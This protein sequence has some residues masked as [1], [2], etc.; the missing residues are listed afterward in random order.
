MRY[1]HLISPVFA[2]G[3]AALS[4]VPAAAGE[5]ART[6]S[7]T[8]TA[9][10]F[11]APDE[12]SFSTGVVS[13]GKTAATA[14]NANSKA[15]AAMI[16]SLKKQGVPEKAIQTANLSLSPQYQPCKPEV[17]C[18]QK[19][20]GYEVSNTLSVTVGVDKAGTVLDAL[21][22][23]GANQIGGI[24]FSIHDTKALL[25]EARA[26]AV[27][28]AIEKAETLA[29]AAGVALGPIQSIHDGGASIP[30]PMFKAMAVMAERAVPLAAGEEEVSANVSIT[31]EIK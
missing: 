2:L 22:A 5:A 31:W 21:V 9:S 27:K 29:K 14:L 16:A 13:Q 24:S 6:L 12:A 3:L 10:V 7:V 19:I 23:A 18:V 11:A 17:V 15:M 30:R 8:G 28:D 26:A 20:T 4:A 25:K 1:K